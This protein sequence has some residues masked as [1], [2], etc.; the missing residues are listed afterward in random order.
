MQLASKKN[1]ELGRSIVCFRMDPYRLKE[2]LVCESSTDSLGRKDSLGKKMDRASW[3]FVRYRIGVVYIRCKL[4]NRF[5]IGLFDVRD[6]N[7]EGFDYKVLERFD[8]L[9][10]LDFKQYGFGEF[11]INCVSFFSS[12]IEAMSYR[13]ILVNRYLD[14]G[15]EYYGSDVIDGV[16]PRLLLLKLK[17]S[18]VDK[19]VNYCVIKGKTVNAVVSALLGRLLNNS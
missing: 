7:S 17:R 5:Y 9:L 18:I 10:S 8:P 6:M 11:E 3:I 4:N 14:L 2:L 13:D 12:R 15:H 19:L 16:V 1:G